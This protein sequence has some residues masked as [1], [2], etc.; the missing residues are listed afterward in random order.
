MKRKRGYLMIMIALSVVS[1]IVGVLVYI[2]GDS[3]DQKTAG[4]VMT[5][6]G[7]AVIWG[8]YGCAYYPF[9]GFSSM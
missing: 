6:I 2:F 5:V 7:P 9:K 1:L 8:V 3:T 4:L